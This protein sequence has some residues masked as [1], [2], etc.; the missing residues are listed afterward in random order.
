MGYKQQI[1]YRFAPYI[2]DITPLYLLNNL[3][4]N[5]R[6]HMVKVLSKTNIFV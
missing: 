1:F 5:K 2:L 4:I 3:H 6:V